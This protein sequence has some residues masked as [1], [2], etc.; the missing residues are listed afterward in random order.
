[1]ERKLYRIFEF[2]QSWNQIFSNS[3]KNLQTVATLLVSEFINEKQFEE[4]AKGLLL[5]T[6]TYPFDKTHPFWSKSFELH[7][8]N[9]SQKKLDTISSRVNAMCEG[10]TA[11]QD[12][13]NKPANLKKPGDFQYL[14]KKFSK[15]KIS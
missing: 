1:M 8:G 7:F 15:E 4:F 10:Q 11:C 3:E 6:Y 9:L 5:G 12:W 13:L 2:Q 14:F